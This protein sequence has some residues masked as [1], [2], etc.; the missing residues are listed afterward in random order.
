MVVV[1][2]LE[3]EHISFHTGRLRRGSLPP[4]PSCFQSRQPGDVISAISCKTNQL[5]PSAGARRCGKSAGGLSW[6]YHQ[7]SLVKIQPTKFS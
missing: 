1:V 5:A 4:S 2:G 3:T 6:S 7:S